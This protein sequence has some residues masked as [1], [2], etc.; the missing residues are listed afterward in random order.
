MYVAGGG[1][2]TLFD[3]GGGDDATQFGV[4]GDVGV[5]LPINEHVGARIAASYTHGFDNDDF[6]NRNILAAVFGISVL[7]GG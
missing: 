2:F 3:F 6:G 5:K 7:L 4:V 1:T